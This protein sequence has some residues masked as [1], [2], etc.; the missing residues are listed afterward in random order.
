MK[1]KKVFASVLSCGVLVG[2]LFVAG[3][4]SA[5]ADNDTP[6]AVSLPPVSSV[7]TLEA[8]FYPGGRDV[9]PQVKIKAG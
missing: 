7:S 1:C 6:L 5:A 8:Q 9:E 2:S 3:P 4:A